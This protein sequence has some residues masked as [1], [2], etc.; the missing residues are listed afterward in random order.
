MY[1][2]NTHDT[3]C[4]IAY[5]SL[6]NRITERCLRRKKTKRN[7]LRLITILLQSELNKRLR[8]KK[9]QVCDILARKHCN[10]V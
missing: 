9:K 2:V 5:Y 6:P 3:S 4:Y 8:S 1:S 7:D 10:T